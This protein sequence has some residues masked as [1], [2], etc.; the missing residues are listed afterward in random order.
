MYVDEI[1]LRKASEGGPIDPATGKKIY[2]KTGRQYLDK[3][4]GQI[5]KAQTKTQ[6]LKITDDARDLISEAT[7]PWNRS[8]HLIPMT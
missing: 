3:K 2:V 7:A 8:T 4:T 5:V 6:K 1:R